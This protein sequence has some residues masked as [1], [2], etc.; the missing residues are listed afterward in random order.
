MILSNNEVTLIKVKKN[1][2]MMIRF[3]GSKTKSTITYE[4]F[5]NNGYY[6]K[7]SLFFLENSSDN[8]Y[9]TVN[10]DDKEKYFL[11]YTKKTDGGTTHYYQFL[12]SLDKDK[13]LPKDDDFVKNIKIKVIIKNKKSTTINKIELE[14][15]VFKELCFENIT[16]TNREESL[17]C[18]E[19]SVSENDSENG[20]WYAESSEDSEND[21]DG[22]ENSI[23]NILKQVK[24]TEGDADLKVIAL[25][26]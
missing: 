10:Y 8:F 17:E 1:K 21:D 23:K 9:V 24:A 25:E 7:N 14:K 13:K 2:H 4:I 22:D 6:Q 18:E 11:K 16:H 15:L 20:F 5:G 26:A 19:E 12:N 3:T